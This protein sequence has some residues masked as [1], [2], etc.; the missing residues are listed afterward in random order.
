MAESGRSVINM[1]NMYRSLRERL[2]HTCAHGSACC[3]QKLL[4]TTDGTSPPPCH[5]CHSLPPSVDWHRAQ[6]LIKWRN[7]R[8]KVG[9]HQRDWLGFPGFKF[10]QHDE[11]LTAT[12]IIS[13][14]IYSASL[15]QGKI[16]S[17][18]SYY[19]FQDLNYMDCQTISVGLHQ[20]VMLHELY[21]SNGKLSIVFQIKKESF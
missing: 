16:G 21:L 10:L 5:V 19:L 9:H 2:Y 8:Q 7:V 15:L 20:R 6:P 18:K 3:I 4:V 17:Y 12:Q 1:G 14:I 13:N 11:F